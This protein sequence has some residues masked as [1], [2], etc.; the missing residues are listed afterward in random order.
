MKLSAKWLQEFVDINI[1]EKNLQ[2]LSQ[3]L[4]MA[5]LAVDACRPCEL[6]PTDFIVE[7]D[8][9]PNR[10]DCLS[11]LGIAREVALLLKQPL[12]QP[13]K[14]L[15]T[16]LTAPLGYTGIN[17]H[18][19]SPEDCPYYTGRVI[20]GLSAEQKTPSDIRQ[21]LQQSDVKLIHPVVDIMNYVMLECGQ[22][23]HAFDYE[24]LNHM[25]D[26]T[27]IPDIF[28]RKA[29]IGEKLVLLD[30]KE[31]CLTDDVLVIAHQT[32]V[33]AL[34]GI[35]GGH[36]TC[37]DNHT[38]AIFIESAFFQPDSIAGR[39]RRYGLRT[40][41]S[42]RFERG[43]DDT[44]PLYALE[45]ATQLLQ[46]IYPDIKI[47]PVIT[48]KYSQYLP[49]NQPILLPY[50]KIKTVLG[51]DLSDHLV[52][53]I[54]TDLGMS[55]SVDMTNP[56]VISVIPPRYRFDIK[57]SI[58]LIEEI[59]RVHGYDQI[60]NDKQ[61]NNINYIKQNHHHDLFKYL[62]IAQGYQEI[63]SYSFISKKSQQQF[64]TVPESELMTLTNPLSAELSVM[65]TNLWTGLVNAVQYNLNRQ[66]HYLKFFEYGQRFTRTQQETVISG[67]WAGKAF[68]EQWGEKQREVDFF[69]IKNNI[70][71][72]LSFTKQNF[73]W[74]TG[75]HPALHPRQTA[76]IF[77]LADHH[78]ISVGFCG[79]LHPDLQQNLAIKMPVFLFELKITTLQLSQAS[80][81]TVHAPIYQAFSDLPTVR[82]DIS[83]VIDDAVTVE[84][85]KNH[86]YSAADPEVI[87]YLSNIIIFDYYQSKSLPEGKKSI[88]LGLL[89]D[90]VQQTF[91]E[92]D[93]QQFMANIIAVLFELGA[94]LR[95]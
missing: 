24:K 78:K 25:N 16:N 70:S 28:I 34:A 73:S 7:F 1:T 65:R 44:L 74:Q 85:I 22:P 82:R 40:E 62:L 77:T 52:K 14:Q 79:A 89:F 63:I 75:S 66:Q 35:M 93:I 15:E 19:Q 68:E 64:D 42:H 5:G 90:P 57:Q 46:Q 95:E 71:Q 84:A 39:A 4:N 86:I 72:L 23:L 47:L 53:A 81:N 83:I 18:V 80:Q 27:D 56:E 55:V 21:K 38:Q 59:A 92:S 6:D 17:V 48:K 20:T 11:A 31:I 87:K 12:K 43:V 91:L 37:I 29:E 88:G 26:Q 54:L 41:A 36:E 50:A 8:L 2:Q 32:K 3:Q 10:G 94:V 9:T 76:E 61:S 13:E 58:D 51:V 45:R 30:Q 67:V 69:D 33:L 49:V 60:N